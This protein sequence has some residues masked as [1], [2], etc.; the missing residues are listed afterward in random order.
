MSSL[1]LDEALHRAVL[2]ARDKREERGA[3][4]DG[5]VLLPGLKRREA[6]ALDSLLSPRKPIIPGRRVRI[7]LSRFEAVL[8]ECGI[9]PLLAYEVVGGRPLRNLPAERE[10][11]SAARASFRAWL[12][13]HDVARFQPQFGAW[14]DDALRQGRIHAG[15]QPLVE[16][17]LRVVSALPSAEPTQRAILSARLLDG[18]PHALD[19][20]T[21]LHRLTVSLLAAGADLDEN[22]PARQVWAAWNVLVDPVSSNV[23]AL[24]LPLVGEGR[25]AGLMRLMPGTH[26]ILTYGQL[27]AGELRWPAG[28]ECFSCENPSVLI[29]AEQA[30]GAACPP[31]ICTGG[32][33][34]DAVRLLL[35]SLRGSGARV[36][37]HGDYDESGVQIL[38]DLEA[39]Y[40]IV[41]WR[42]DAAS[43]REALRRI[44]RPVP[45]APPEP[46]ED[47]VRALS[48]PVAE[49]LVIDELLADLRA[50]GTVRPAAARD[51]N[52]RRE[53]GVLQLFGL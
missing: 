33:P 26:V 49:E 37:H 45:D 18:D 23:A 52:G 15:M 21:P 50:A 20:D 16:Q 9:D 43:L 53:R 22:T 27:A 38:R 25:L 6:L 34:S 46:L 44:G 35:T 24:N 11:R 40:G 4:G 39:R 29:A 36:R 31:L 42:F 41:P 13:R 51:K 8:R 28:V 32:H 47:A 1:Q 30:L 14:L 17:A 48:A 19:V 5:V 7:Q 10:Q 2:A 12:A 3:T